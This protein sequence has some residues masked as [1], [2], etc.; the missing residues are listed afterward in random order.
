MIAIFA[1]RFA[2]NESGERQKHYDISESV[3]IL[4]GFL[5]NALHRAGLESLTHIPNPMTFLNTILEKPGNERPFILLKVGHAS[6]DA[7]IPGA[8]TEKKPL[9]KIASFLE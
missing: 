9:S 7:S 4:T 2:I 1:E 6:Q 3:G 8:S 5:I